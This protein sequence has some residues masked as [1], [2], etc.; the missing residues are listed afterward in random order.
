MEASTQTSSKEIILITG[1]SGLIGTRVI[2][3][4]ADQY[5]CIGLDKMGNPYANPK[6]ENITVDI[7]SPDSI[8]KRWKE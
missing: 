7:T 3:Q 6:A 1:G 2:D 8:Q 5:Q 4:L